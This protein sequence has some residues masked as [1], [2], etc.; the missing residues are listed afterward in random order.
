MRCIPPKMVFKHLRGKVE[1]AGD[2][3][4]WQSTVAGVGGS[5][6]RRQSVAA[7]GRNPARNRAKQGMEEGLAPA[8]VGAPA[9]A[10]RR[11]RSGVST[12]RRRMAGGRRPMMAGGG[13]R[14]PKKKK[15]GGFI[16]ARG[17]GKEGKQRLGWFNFCHFCL[18]LFL[19]KFFLPFSCFPSY[20]LAFL[21]L[22]LASLNG[23]ALPIFIAKVQS[24]LSR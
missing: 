7:G 23:L 21:S 4:W 20:C 1:E 2:C 15:Q 8:T 11:K 6:G 14:R 24:L 22:L 10:Q 19:A 5:S 17:R 12:G 16:R 18:V 9:T 13:K 3:R